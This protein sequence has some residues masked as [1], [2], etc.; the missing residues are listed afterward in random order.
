MPG[1]RRLLSL[2]HQMREVPRMKILF[3]TEKVRACFSVVSSRMELAS[4]PGWGAVDQVP[5]GTMRTVIA[6]VLC[7]Q[8]AMSR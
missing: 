2:Y 1:G 7:G 4:P 6:C 3:C 5:L 8:R